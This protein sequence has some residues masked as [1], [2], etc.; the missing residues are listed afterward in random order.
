MLPL[1]LATALLFSGI[2][3]F[4][5]N[6]KRRARC[7]KQLEE[8]SRKPRILFLSSTSQSNRYG[9]KAPTSTEYVSVFPPSQRQALARV[10]ETQPH[11]QAVIARHGLSVEL[12]AASLTPLEANYLDCDNDIFTPTGI[13]LE[14]V[15]LLGDFPNYAELSGIPLPEPYENFNIENALPR[16]YRPFRWA[17]HQTMCRKNAYIERAASY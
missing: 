14:E 17:Y 12:S 5:C 6:K 3:F 8:W 7:R 11:L 16:P 1:V 9:Q 2:V 10:A 15:K 4:A 13:S